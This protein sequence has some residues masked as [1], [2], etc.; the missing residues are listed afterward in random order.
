MTSTTDSPPTVPIVLF[1]GPVEVGNSTV[2]M[3]AARLLKTAQIPHA[4]VDLAWSAVSWP[5][6]PDDPWNERLMYRNLACM[7][8]NFRQAGVERLILCRVLEDRSVLS[9]IIE[10]VPGAKI[11]VIGLR[12]GLA[13]LHP[14]VRHQIE[15][16][17]MDNEGR[18]AAEIA[19]EA[20]RLA[21][22]L[23]THS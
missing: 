14:R 2:A 11:T 23:N 12:A 10:A 20:L 9:P 3:E 6:P 1:T 13:E 7:W 15:D 4:L 5:R 8:S 16:H 22:W 19:K 17:V 21:G 18:S